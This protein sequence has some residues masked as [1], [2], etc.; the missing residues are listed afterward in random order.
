MAFP[1]KMIL[2]PID[3]DE[4]SEMALDKTIE[5]ART[6]RQQPYPRSRATFGSHT[7]GI[8]STRRIVGGPGESGSNETRGYRE[9]ETCRIEER[10]SCLHR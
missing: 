10:V 4:N 9:E 2:C 3:F 6:F 8:S 1:F 5:I 7:G